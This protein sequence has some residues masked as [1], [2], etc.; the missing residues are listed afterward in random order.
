MSLGGA[1]EELPR[2]LAAARVRAVEEEPR[3]PA[4][5]RD[6]GAQLREALHPEAAGPAAA[7]P[8]L[9]GGG[10]RGDRCVSPLRLGEFQVSIITD[11]HPIC[12]LTSFI[13]SFQPL[14]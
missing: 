7:D 6:H 11:F 9:V 1:D 10:G 13:T 5:A 12:Y 8:P 2:R 4:P 14:I 3:A